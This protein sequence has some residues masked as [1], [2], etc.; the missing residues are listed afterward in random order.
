[1]E[2]R[3]FEPLTPSM[4]TR[5]ATGLRY[6]P[7][8]PDGNRPAT[9]LAGGREDR[10][11]RTRPRASCAVMSPLYRIE[12]DC[13]RT[14]CRGRPTTARRAA[15]R[16]SASRRCVARRAA[17]RRS[18]SRRTSACC[19]ASQAASRASRRRRRRSASAGVTQVNEVHQQERGGD[20]EA[21]PEAGADEHHADQL[22]DV[23]QQQ[24]GE[25][26]AAAVDGRGAPGGAAPGAPPV[27]AAL[28]ASPTAPGGGPRRRSAAGRVG[29][30]VGHRRP[31]GVS[32]EHARAG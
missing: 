27:R 24:R 17:S 10:L 7:E 32:H 22:D 30:E 3:G 9:R 19:S 21:D 28:R 16:C 23:E 15:S 2:L 25:D 14:P 5:C 26:P 12:Y 8:P 4:R 18:C 1:M 11:L 31:A 29:A 13:P 6:S 20:R